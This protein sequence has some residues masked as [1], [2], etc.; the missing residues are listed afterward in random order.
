MDNAQRTVQWWKC[1]LTCY[2]FITGVA[3][4]YSSYQ[5]LSSIMKL[6]PRVLDRLTTATRSAPKKCLLIVWQNSVVSSSECVVV[7]YLVKIYSW[8]VIVL[9]F[10]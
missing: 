3:S 6:C 9:Y 8:F 4:Y 5:R 10:S 2:M 7:L 1:E